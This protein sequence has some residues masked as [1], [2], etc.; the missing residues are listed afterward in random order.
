MCIIYGQLLVWL[1]S[2]NGQCVQVYTGVHRCVQVCT[3]IYRCVQV[4]TGIYKCT[5]KSVNH[6]HHWPV[7]QSISPTCTT[8]YLSIT[9]FPGV[10]SPV[11]YPRYLFSPRCHSLPPVTYLD[12]P[13]PASSIW[14][15]NHWPHQVRTEVTMTSYW[16]HNMTSYY[17][18]IDPIPYVLRSQW[19]H[20]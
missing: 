5:G 4:Y 20:C 16:G 1:W 9:T 15:S 10:V 3:G 6:S 13:V 17:L 18:I 11:S 7:N 14:V 19:R 2:I 12:L 8:S